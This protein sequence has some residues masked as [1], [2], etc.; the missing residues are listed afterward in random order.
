MKHKFQS[1]I[2]TVVLAALAGCAS[3]PLNEPLKEID[4]TAGYRMNSRTLSENN[5]DDMFVIL[6]LSGGGFR[7][8]ALDY[9]VIRYL[10]RIQFGDDGRSLLD[11]VDVI[12]SS[13]GAS[14]PA[15]YYGVFGKDVFLSDFLDD[16]LYKRMQSDYTWKVLNPVH[17]PRLASGTFSRGDLMVEYLDREVFH[18]RTFADMLQE[19]PLVLLNATDMGQGTHFSFVQGHFDLICSDLTPFPVSRAVTASMAFTPAFTAI[20]LNN[21]N[22]GRCGFV[23][24]TWVTQALNDGVEQNPSLYATALDVVSY[25]DIDNRPFI[26]LLDSGVSDN[27]GI[28]SPATAF[29]VRDS[30]ASQ[31]D[32]IEDGTIKKLVIML[33]NARAKVDF[34]GDLSP[35]PPGMITSVMAAAGQPL[36]N[37]SFE[38]VNL[39]KRDI[40]D[41]RINAIRYRNNRQSCSALVEELTADLDLDKADRKEAEDDCFAKFG[42]SDEDRPKDLDIYLIHINF[43]LLEDIEARERFQFIPT[44]LQ[45]PKEDVDALVDIAP[46]LMHEDPEFLHLLKDIDAD[47]TN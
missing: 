7:A 42:A 25:Q 31:M 47:V 1:L 41:T 39:L 3:Y 24:P 22:D 38:T 17:W 12:S 23:T 11:E 45:L 46:V 2:A 26:H 30:P 9:G 36:D 14:L 20:T 8:A 28:R 27:M 32:R 4:V 6:A 37:F 35:K 43:D 21:Y 13:S 18:E 33:V 16:V 5:S 40:Q 44:T 19:R 34:S 15:A 10:D 29:T